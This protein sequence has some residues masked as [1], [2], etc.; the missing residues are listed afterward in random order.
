MQVTSLAQNKNSYVTQLPSYIV[1]TSTTIIIRANFRDLFATTIRHISRLLAMCVWSILQTY[2]KIIVSSHFI[3]LQLRQSTRHAYVCTRTCKNGLQ[4]C[5]SRR[6]ALKALSTFPVTKW[7]LQRQ[8]APLVSMAHVVMLLYTRVV[9]TTNTVLPARLH[10]YL[11]YHHFIMSTI[12]TSVTCQTNTK[13]TDSTKYLTQLSAGSYLH[14][15]TKR[16]IVEI[17]D[18]C[19]EKLQDSRYHGAVQVLFQLNCSE[20]DHVDVERWQV[21]Q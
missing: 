13:R 14:I 19:I 3:W 21:Q 11:S 20:A 4:I 10:I 18:I 8:C 7:S 15:C 17:V 1:G 5:E 6:H 9:T 2:K 16:E 12:V